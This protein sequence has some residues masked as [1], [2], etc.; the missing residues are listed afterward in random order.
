MGNK[1]SSNPPDVKKSGAEIRKNTNSK[2][3]M[4]QGNLLKVQDNL[5]RDRE[6]FLINEY[7]K[8]KNNFIN[9]VK[10]IS[11]LLN[12]INLNITN[13]NDNNILSY[14][15]Y[16]DYFSDPNKTIFNISFDCINEILNK[17]IINGYEEQMKKNIIISSISNMNF[18]DNV[19]LQL[20]HISC[21]NNVNLDQNKTSLISYRE[22]FNSY[23]DHKKYFINFLLY[24]N[25]SDIVSVTSNIED[26]NI[27][28]L[29]E[30]S[31]KLDTIDILVNKL[32]ILINSNNK[33][34]NI[35]I[36]LSRKQDGGN[37]KNKPSIIVRKE[38]LGKERCIYKKTGDRK[39]YVKY[40]G[41]L[42]T[43]KDY[44]KIIKAR[45]NKRI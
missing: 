5:L 34:G 3:L 32:L 14:I 2:S 21:S 27:E 43:V 30:K 24:L 20:I 39:E 25:I 37:N 17:P 36:V 45:N 16:I 26:L 10:N 11:N 41:N 29:Q 19:R 6:N 4:L 7:I 42:I 38:I 13:Y 8:Y 31:D 1:F 33:K 28:Y 40:K 22:E 44:K 35:E 9:K 23:S 15:D 12:Q 18:F